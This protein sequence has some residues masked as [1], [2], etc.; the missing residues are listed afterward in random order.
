MRDCEGYVPTKAVGAAVEGREAAVLNALGIEWN[1]K[2]RHILCPYPDHP[3][4]QPSWRWDEKRKLAF[5]TCIGTRPGEKKAHSIF[6][7]VCAKEKI[8]RDAAKIRIAQIIGRPELTI[9]GKGQKYQRTD[10][11]TL[12]SPPPENRDDALCWAYL[13]HRLGIEPENVPPA[14]TQVV[15]IKALAY[16][17]PPQRRG[18]NP[19]RVGEFPAAIFET[20]DCEGNQH[21]H[22]IYLSPGG[23]GKA[24]LGIAPDGTRRREKKSAKKAK[25]DNTAGRAVIWGDA[26]RAETAM[27]FE[28]IET[29]AAA[30]LAFKPDIAS[31]KIMIAACI[32]A[33]GIE[34][35][36]PWPSTSRVIVGADRRGFQQWAR[37]ITARRGCRAEIR[38]PASPRDFCFDRVAGPTRREDGLARCPSAR[39]C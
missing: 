26:S 22:R 37:P 25:D 38:R 10:A 34:A 12:L 19:V 7:V 23:A 27:I 17:D 21:A 14:A 24:E 28:G 29:A 11:A 32:T 18:G 16:H 8:D 33:S 31:G 1:G 4:H 5:C 30:A 36:E 35:F 13:G 2:A 6:G 20:I 15:G 39:W 9:R 3:D